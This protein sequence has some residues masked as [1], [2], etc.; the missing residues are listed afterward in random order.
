MRNFRK[1]QEILGDLPDIKKIYLLG[2]TG[3]GKTSLVQNI[4]GTSEFGFPTTSQKRTTVAPTEYVINKELEFKTTVI[5]KKKEDILDSIKE[6]IEM[7][8]IRAYEGNLIIED[9]IFELEQTPD[10]RFKLKHIISPDTFKNKASYI[11]NSILP[12]IENTDEDIFSNQNIIMEIENITNEFLHEIETHFN[13][14]CSNSYKL[15]NDE[16]F[17]IEGISNKNEFIKRNKELLANETGSISV[18]VEYIRIQGDLLANWLKPD[19]SFVLIDGEGNGHTYS[20]KRD[21]LSTRH[22][23][24]FNFCNNIVLVENSTEPFTTGGQGAIESIFLNGYKNKF[25]LIFSKI[26]KLTIADTNSYFRRN[27]RNLSEALKK[28]DVLFDIENKNTFKVANLNKKNSGTSER[29]EIEKLLLS[30]NESKE[31]EIIPLEYD[32]N[33][34]LINLN[35]NKFI[36]EFQDEILPEHWA[37]IKAF[38]KRMLLSEVEYKHIKPISWILRF[39]MQEI[40]IFLRRSDDLQSDISD[41]QNKIKQD[42]SKKLI[43]YIYKSFIFDQDHLWLQAFELKGIGSD[44]ARKT[45]IF[46]NILKAFLPSKE[47]DSAFQL[48]KKNIKNLLLESGAKELKSAVKIN[49]NHIDIKKIYG[50]SNVKWDLEQNTNILLGKNGSGK[51][52]VIKLIDACINNNKEVFE[53][54][55]YPYVELTLTKEYENG[56]KQEIK[57][58]N[59]K[60]SSDIKSVLI[61]TFDIFTNNSPDKVTYLDS[62]LH[63]LIE[64]FGKY[65]RSL[66]QIIAKKTQT[67][68]NQITEILNKISVASPEELT[69][70]QKLR[71]K[72]NKINSEI[73]EPIQEFKSILD[74]Y[75]DTT[76]KT[77]IINDEKEPLL[78]EFKGI[79][80]FIPT[81][82]LSSGEKQLLIIFLTIILQKEKP[83]ILLMDEPETSLHVEWQSSLIDNIR[84]IKPNIQIIIATHNPLITLNR[85]ENEIGVIEIGNEVIETNKIGTKYLD[86]STILLKYFELP[87]LIGREM[88][89]DIKRFT[90]LKLKNASLLTK[91][92]SIEL[93]KITL[94]LENNL[95]GDIIYNK[96]YL[97]FLKFLKENKDVDFDKFEEINETDFEIFLNEFKDEFND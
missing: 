83:F 62:K 47:N 9:I 68:D 69:Q 17:I 40:N 96:N 80:N 34:L 31:S 41:S 28:E 86:I 87:S 53:H 60:I 20:E 57:I 15:F 44:K 21:T 38:S 13:K 93:E 73:Y 84:K 5:L 6:L 35:S 76:N 11:Y 43:W 45:F 59:S 64:D 97:R 58:N 19:L 61:S 27:L 89:N 30:I 36:N 56:E 66:T 25:K 72:V 22:H 90:E 92:E 14:K 55:E 33:N 12:Q 51:S 29:N 94:L 88:Q 82:K 39:L 48:F 67:E 65:Q 18:L 49:L 2:S 42:F 37:V 95:V 78:I 4:I 79:N 23:D 16:P 75:L 8:I 24:Y 50:N 10:E 32:F 71:I 52:T 63:N 85:N 26:D 91:E 74:F 46:E 77:A 7:A 81:D 1:I 70:F 54:Y 3:A